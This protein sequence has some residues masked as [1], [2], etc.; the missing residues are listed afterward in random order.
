MWGLYFSGVVLAILGGVGVFLLFSLLNTLIPK[1]TGSKDG[2]IGLFLFG[3]VVAFFSITY[4]VTSS[5]LQFLAAFA[6]LIT[7]PLLLLV[8]H[9]YEK[10]SK[11]NKELEKARENER[12]KSLTPAQRRKELAE[13]NK[14]LM[15]EERLRAERARQESEALTERVHGKIVKKLVCPHCQSA[16][17]VRRIEGLSQEKYLNANNLYRSRKVTKMKCDSCDTRWE[18]V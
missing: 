14:K 17:S 11:K 4:F 16:G 12:L 1:R 13:K 2:A 3:M 15:E 6:G 5:G 10:Q 18:V 7:I 8:S 9:F